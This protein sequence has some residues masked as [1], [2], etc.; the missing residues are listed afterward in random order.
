MKA[1]GAIAEW[2]VGSFVLAKDLETR[3]E[4]K[5]PLHLRNH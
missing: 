5:T 3:I 4:A 2:V 1:D